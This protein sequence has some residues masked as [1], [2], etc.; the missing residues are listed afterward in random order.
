ML[1][2]RDRV[3]SLLIRLAPA[4]GFARRQLA[5]LVP[6]LEVVLRL[7]ARALLVAGKGWQRLR[8]H[9]GPLVRKA[10]QWLR[11]HAGPFVK[12][13]WQWLVRIFWICM[14]CCLLYTSDAADE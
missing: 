13:C 9:A 2:L 12:K 14:H 10:W 4:V 6:L 11:I 8:I 3:E 5:R 1:Q 7:L